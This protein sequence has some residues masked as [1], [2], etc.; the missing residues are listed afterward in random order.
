MLDRWTVKSPHG[1]EIT[2]RIKGSAES[3]FEHSARAEGR[4]A[5]MVRK[6]KVLTRAEV[7]KL[8]TEYVKKT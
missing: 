8:F 3:G 2:F 6:W 7:E 1:V 4:N 5:A